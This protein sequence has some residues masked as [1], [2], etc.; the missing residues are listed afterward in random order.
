MSSANEL[1]CKITFVGNFEIIIKKSTGPRTDP[2]GTPLKHF[3]TV[4]KCPYSH[5]KYAVSQVGFNPPKQESTDPK[6]RKRLAHLYI[7][8]F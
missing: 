8:T 6:L 2:C 5:F 4:T 7:E 1:T 3:I